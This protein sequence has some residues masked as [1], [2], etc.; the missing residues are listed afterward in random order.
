[1]KIPP[2]PLWVWLV[3]GVLFLVAIFLPLAGL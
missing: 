3:L 1:M 2:P